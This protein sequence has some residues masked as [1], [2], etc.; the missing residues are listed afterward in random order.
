MEFR[1]LRT[2]RRGR[3]QRQLL[4]TSAMPASSQ[5]ALSRQ[6]RRLEPAIGGTGCFHR[7]GRGVVLTNSGERMLRGPRA[8]GRRRRPRQD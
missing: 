4:A 7:T 5:S 2:F 1:Q 8:P 3:R 6:R